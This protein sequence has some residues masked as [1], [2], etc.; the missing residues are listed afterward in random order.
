[1]FFRKKNF[2]VKLHS[3]NFSKFVNQYSYVLFNLIYFFSNNFFLLFPQAWLAAKLEEAKER[4]RLEA[5]NKPDPSLEQRKRED[6][7]SAYQE[8]LNHK[9]EQNKTARQYEERRRSEEAGQFVI[10]DRHLCDEAFK[11]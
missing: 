7:E 11:R 9:R 10:R 4:R 5:Q 2:I 3:A 8:W 1:M 6:A